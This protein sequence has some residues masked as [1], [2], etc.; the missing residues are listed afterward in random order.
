[1]A[2]LV[3]AHRLMD[4]ERKQKM[5]HIYEAK[6]K[7]KETIAR[8][9]HG[10]EQRFATAV[11]ERELVDEESEDE[12]ASLEDDDSYN[13]D[14]YDFTSSRSLLAAEGT[15]I[16]SPLIQALPSTTG[17]T[18][19]GNTETQ[20][21]NSKAEKVQAVLKGIKWVELVSEQLQTR[22][23][24]IMDHIVLHLGGCI[25]PWN[26]LKTAVAVAIL[27]SIALLKRVSLSYHAKGRSGIRERERARCQPTVV[28]REITAGEEAEIAKLKVHNFCKLTKR[29]KC[30]VP[31]TLPFGIA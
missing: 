23:K 6:E 24:E 2:S 1:M 15:P 5:G 12:E 20:R 17:N 19:T 3:A 14:D 13:E 27:Q 11:E 16:S 10:L 28:V 22:I 31:H 9:L 4:G 8:S 21:V 7:A 26:V 29:E 30:L 18:G 25:G